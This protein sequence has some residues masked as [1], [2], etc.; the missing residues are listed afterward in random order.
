MYKLVETVQI[1]DQKKMPFSVTVQQVSSTVVV[2]R[3]I[4]INVAQYKIALI[5]GL[6]WEIRV[7]CLI[8]FLFIW[9]D[10]MKMSRCQLWKQYC[11]RN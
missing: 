11:L 2:T 8:A 9:G 1:A 5:P 7:I 10:I 4:N 3:R 6:L